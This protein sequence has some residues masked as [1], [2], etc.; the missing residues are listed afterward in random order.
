MIFRVFEGELLVVFSLTFHPEVFSKVCLCL[1]DFI[2]IVRLLMAAVSKMTGTLA[3][4]YSSD[5]T[6]RELS[7]EYQHGRVLIVF[8]NLSPL[9]L[10]TKVALVL[11][12]SRLKRELMLRSIMLF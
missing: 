5:S 11:G 10:C 7:T 3:H 1:Q 12:G 9:V 2:N 8:E 4:G 6:R